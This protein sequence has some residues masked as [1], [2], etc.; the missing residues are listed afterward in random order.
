MPHFDILA[1][2]P[3]YV[4][5]NQTMIFCE[6]LFWGTDEAGQF[7][8]HVFPSSREKNRFMQA[9]CGRY[10]RMECPYA[11]YMEAAYEEEEGI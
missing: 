11:A 7:T 4:R 3:Y 8:A 2:C 9:H 6:S 5:E 10:P 1:Q